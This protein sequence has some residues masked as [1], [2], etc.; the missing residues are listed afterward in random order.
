MLDVLPTKVQHLRVWGICFLIKGSKRL[1]LFTFCCLFRFRVGPRLHLRNGF[2][3]LPLRGNV[4]RSSRALSGMTAYGTNSSFTKCRYPHR[5][6]GRVF[7]CIEEEWCSCEKWFWKHLTYFLQ[8][9]LGGRVRV[10]VTG[11]APISPSVLTFLRASLGC[12]V[13]K[14]EMR[15]WNQKQ[16]NIWLLF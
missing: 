16:M 3:T 5:L 12:Q 7:E 9:S 8:E 4:Q 1:S 6:V 13:R 11:A 2:W 14:E 15:V 10:M